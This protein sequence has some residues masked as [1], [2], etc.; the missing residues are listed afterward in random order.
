[1]N[2]NAANLLRTARRASGL[3]Q[4]QLAERLGVSQAAVA[5]LEAAGCN[6]TLATLRRALG[7]A[8]YR[9]ELRTSPAPSNV[10]A[11]LIADRLRQSPAERLRAFQASHARMATLAGTAARVRGQ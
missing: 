2:D 1:M 8:G 9:L 3:S 7:A 4:V 6:P 5:R 10:D 11:S